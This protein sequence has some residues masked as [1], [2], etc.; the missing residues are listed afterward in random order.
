VNGR[1]QPINYLWWLVSRASGIVALVLIAL[2]VVMGLA[3]ATK[4]LPRPAVRRGT[5]R[6]HEHVALA[7]LLATGAHGLALLGDQWLKPGWSGITVPFALGY[8]PQFTGIGIIGG[9]LA[10]LLGPT[11]YLRRRIG[12]RRWRRLHSLIVLAWIMAC[13]H[14]LGAGSDRHQ[15][16][17]EALVLAPAV[18]IVYLLVLRLGTAQWLRRFA[19]SNLIKQGNRARRRVERTVPLP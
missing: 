12:A 3:M 16:W 1:K 8:R 18:P 4:I 19:L 11:Y 15:R 2:S 10:L 6:L 17:L 9:Y 5:A 14:T 7:A 13:V